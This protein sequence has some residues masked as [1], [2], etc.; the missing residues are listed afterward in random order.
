MFYLIK[1]IHQDKKDKHN[2]MEKLTKQSI[3]T[4]TCLISLEIYLLIFFYE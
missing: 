3:A 1:E 4:K 2:L